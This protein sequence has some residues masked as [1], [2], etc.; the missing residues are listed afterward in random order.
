MTGLKLAQ[1]GVLEFVTNSTRLASMLIRL[2]V[3]TL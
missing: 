2:V 1:C 3:L